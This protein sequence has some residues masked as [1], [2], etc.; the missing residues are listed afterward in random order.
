MQS[1]QMHQQSMQM[2]VESMQSSQQSMQ[3]VHQSQSVQVFQHHII[4]QPYACF[5]FFIHV[6]FLFNFVSKHLNSILPY[7]FH[8]ARYLYRSEGIPFTDVILTK[9]KQKYRGHPKALQ[10]WFLRRRFYFLI[11]GAECV[12]VCK[13]HTL[14]SL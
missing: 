9:F 5:F 8:P 10:L 12:T 4:C 6:Q 13:T 7:F 11:S 2:Q 3:T 14:N 1:L